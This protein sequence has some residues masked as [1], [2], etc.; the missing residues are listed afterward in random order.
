MTEGSVVRRATPDDVAAIVRV[1]NDAFEVE[2][3]FKTAPRTD[4][5]GVRALMET[6]E[7][8]VIV[9]EDGALDGA[10]YLSVIGSR[11]YLGMLSVTPAAQGRGI[12]RR[13]HDAAEH[14]CRAAGCDLLEIHL[15]DIRPELFSY[16]ERLGF[17]PNGET[18]PFPVPQHATQPCHLVV[19]TKPV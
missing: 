10:V 6:G 12:G 9:G 14:Q 7:F 4:D 11:G 13:L 8:L 3:F 2:R 15:V 16:Y 5:A 19:M 1:V 18:R 17:E